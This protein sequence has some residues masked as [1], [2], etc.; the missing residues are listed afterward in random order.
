MMNRESTIVDQLLSLWEG[1]PAFTHHMMDMDPH[2]PRG[3]SRFDFVTEQIVRM[4]RLVAG[5][6]RRLRT[7]VAY[8]PIRP[9]AL[10]VVHRALTTDGCIGVKFY[11]PSGYKPVENADGEIFGD[12]TA[13]EVNR[14]NLELFQLCVAL[15][16][17]L[18]AHCSPGGMERVRGRTGKYSDPA[19]W[20]QALQLDGLAALRLCLGHAGGEDSWT[21]PHSMRGDSQWERSW[22]NA[23]VSLCTQYRNVYCEF[24]HFD[25]VL[26]DEQRSK[27][28]RRL[29]R[30]VDAHGD[31]FG[32][33]M[34]FG[35]D[36]HPLSRV[37]RFQ[38]VVRVWRA[39]LRSST[40]LAPYEAA[41]FGDNALAYP[42]DIAAGRGSRSRHR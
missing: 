35:G 38:D 25:S 7:F 28:R 4:Q 14:R 3:R 37:P 21:A 11:P 42:A 16:A 2:Y 9:N 36:W 1:T 34:M 19:H 18:F 31:A 12:A 15:D 30:V 13:A 6:G 20:R 27:L 5:Y 8:C 17:P 40:V 41:F 24:G 39:M 22:G 10:D 32:R 23:V 33:K 26:D 29:E